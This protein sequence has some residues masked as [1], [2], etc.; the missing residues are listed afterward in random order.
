MSPTR[1]FFT[2]NPGETVTE[3]VTLHNSSNKDYVLSV[4]Y[5]DWKREL[6]GN[7]VYFESGTLKNSNASWLSTL[8]NTVSVAAGA[9]MEVLVAMQVPEEASTSEVTNSMLFFTQLPTQEDKTTSSSTGLGIIT[10]F[11]FGLHV[12]YTPAGNKLKSLEITNIE[13]IVDAASKKAAISI[14][15]DGNVV[16]DATVEFELI[17][18]DTG[19]EIKL[20]P[21]S[22]SMMPDTHQVV[23][24]ILP[25]NLAGNYLGVTI[26]KMAGTSDMRVGEKNFSF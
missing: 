16:N 3:L 12:Y 24:F 14:T 1:L 5:K 13:E 21:I 18:T 6:D 4:N 2:G 17:N 23:E 19:E 8:E 22:I 7:K 11:E 15:N 26:I 25:E 9:T 20:D 10:L